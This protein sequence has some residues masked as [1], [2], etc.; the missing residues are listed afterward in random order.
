MDKYINAVFEKFDEC[1]N[2]LE[3][4]MDR[5]FKNKVKPGTKIR[6]KKGSTVYLGNDIYATLSEDTIATIAESKNKR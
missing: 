6:I 4:G 2:L 1:M 5:V 3:K